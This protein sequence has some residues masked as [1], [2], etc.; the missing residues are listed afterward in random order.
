MAY[1]AGSL[2][3]M[4]SGNGHNHY[5]YDTL[6]A[7]SAAMVLN[8]FNNSDDNLNLEVGDIITWVDWT[9]AVS[10]SGTINAYGEHIVMTVGSTGTGVIDLASVGAAGVVTNT[11]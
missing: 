7:S 2:V 10:S 3:L 1:E 4:A 5:R 11:N 6:E 9:G 8:Y